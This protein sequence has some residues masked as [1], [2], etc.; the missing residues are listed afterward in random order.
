MSNEVSHLR[1]CGRLFHTKGAVCEKLLSPKVLNFVVLDF[2]KC[3]DA[4]L[5]V[6]EGV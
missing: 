2:N 1:D 6:L 5:K 3:W 4:D